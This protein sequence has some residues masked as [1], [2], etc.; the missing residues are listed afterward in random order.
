M[1]ASAPETRDLILTVAIVVM[2]ARALNFAFAPLGMVEDGSLTTTGRLIWPLLAIFATARMRRFRQPAN[3]DWMLT[4]VVMCVVASSAWSVTPSRTLYQGIVLVSLLCCARYLA[5]AWERTTLVRLLA[6]TLAV[7]SAISLVAVLA[8]LVSASTVRGLFEHKNIFGQV[9]AIAAVLGFVTWRSHQVRGGGIRRCLTAASVV[10]VLLSDSKAAL[11]MMVLGGLVVVATAVADALPRL[12]ALGGALVFAGGVIAI[13]RYLPS[14]SDIM[15]GLDRS[16]DLTGRSEVWDHALTRAQLRPLSGWGYLSY[17][18]EQPVGSAPNG[19]D[20]L[21]ASQA[22]NGYLEMALGVGFPAAALLVATMV[23][24]IVKSFR[25]VAAGAPGAV[26]ALSM[27]AAFT[28]HNFVEDV[29]PGSVQTLPIVVLAA[30][31]AR[32]PSDPT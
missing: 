19:R 25:R 15:A 6:T 8:G 31:T 21:G 22:H 32:T 24:L 9:S 29:I 7:V 26:A 1:A 16:E 27:S 30:L 18:V 23:N 11:V 12:V 4:V 28:V 3:L 10:A 14:A 5:S 2:A 20:I 17:W 13:H